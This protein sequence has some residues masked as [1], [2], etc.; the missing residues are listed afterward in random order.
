MS[1]NTIDTQKPKAQYVYLSSADLDNEFTDF[2]HATFNLHHSIE[3]EDG[4]HLVYGITEIGFN[5]TANNISENLD[6]NKLYVDITYTF[7]E[8]EISALPNLPNPPNYAAK[9]NPNAGQ[10]FVANCTFLFPDGLYATLDDL[11]TMMSDMRYNHI[12]SFI[13]STSAIDSVSDPLYL[14]IQLSWVQ[15]PAGF[16][17]KPFFQSGAYTV[18]NALTATLP[19]NST[20]ILN[21]IQYIPVIKKITI[22]KKGK[23]YDLLFTNKTGHSNDHPPNIPAYDSITGDN[24]PTAIHFDIL[25]P[26]TQAQNLPT[27]FDPFD[28]VMFKA[29]TDVSKNQDPMEKLAQSLASKSNYNQFFLNSSPFECFYKPLLNPIYIDISSDLPGEAVSSGKANVGKSIL[30]R[31]FILGGNNGATSFYQKYENPIWYVMDE[32]AHL[33]S[34]RIAIESEKNKWDFYN[35]GYHIEII[36]YQVHNEIADRSE[37]TV[38]QNI[39]GGGSEVNAGGSAVDDEDNINDVDEQNLKEF[40]KT[41]TGRPSELFSMAGDDELTP[42]FSNYRRHQLH[43]QKRE[44]FGRKPA[45]M[46]IPNSKR[47]RER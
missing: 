31:I 45:Y 33:Q 35:L 19:D 28:N 30:K 39:M 44:Q 5:A 42:L 26:W 37:N 22:K 4:Y 15:T 2:S 27:A 11:F 34:V 36:F 32:N 38:V 29:Y 9:L 3:P 46:N 47:I 43:A 40:E 18:S 10:D 13:L 12:P 7:S 41:Y 20:I 14:P 1:N 23:L 25:M 16:T 21:A 6:N 17:V 24:P 8:Y